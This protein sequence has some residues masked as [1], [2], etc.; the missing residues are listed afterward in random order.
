MAKGEVYQRRRRPWQREEKAKGKGLSPPFNNSSSVYFCQ[1]LNFL[2]LFKLY[3]SS[4][5]V[6]YF[7]IEVDIIKNI[8]FFL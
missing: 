5:L 8:Y 4:I 6:S 3:F 7:Q 2:N 1:F